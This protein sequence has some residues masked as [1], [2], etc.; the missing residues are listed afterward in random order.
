MALMAFAA[1]A[2]GESRPVDEDCGA[3]LAPTEGVGIGC[4]NAHPWP[5]TLQASMMTRSRE[6]TS[7]STTTPIPPDFDAPDRSTVIDDEDV[8]AMTT[9]VPSWLA[10]TAAFGMTSFSTACA[11]GAQ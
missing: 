10:I 7:D 8:R 9:H 4:P 6:D 11:I 1:A 2:S 5:N 3:G